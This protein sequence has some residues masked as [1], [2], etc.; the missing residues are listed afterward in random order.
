MLADKPSFF[1]RKWISKLFGIVRYNILTSYN[2]TIL[3]FVELFGDAQNYL[4]HL[5]AVI[6]VE[7][8]ASNYLYFGFFICFIIAPL[9]CYNMETMRFSLTLPA[10]SS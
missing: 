4:V 1:I 7:A 6:A 5:A 8:C 10:I 3:P 2:T 9:F